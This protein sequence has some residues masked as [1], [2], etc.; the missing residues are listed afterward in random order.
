MEHLQN[1]NR[2]SVIKKNGESIFIA[3]TA[4]AT[5]IKSNKSDSLCNRDSQ[6]KV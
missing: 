4:D 1:G 5:S 2:R 6:W 3:A